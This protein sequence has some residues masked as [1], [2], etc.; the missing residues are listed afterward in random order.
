[1]P[2]Y[3]NISMPALEESVYKYNVNSQNI[4]KGTI[5]QKR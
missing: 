4:K 2:A 1:M 3:G 5:V